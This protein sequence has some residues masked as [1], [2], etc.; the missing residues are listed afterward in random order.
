M[1]IKYF[2]IGNRQGANQ[3]RK[4]F[5]FKYTNNKNIQKKFLDF[6]SSY[7]SREDNSIAIPHLKYNYVFSLRLMSAK[8]NCRPTKY[9]SE[10]S[11]IKLSFFLKHLQ[12]SSHHNQ[13]V[14]S[15]HGISSVPIKEA[16]INGSP[17]P[18]RADAN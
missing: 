12:V 18:R 10:R 15:L 9:I 7:Y 13:S 3:V 8:P 1:A 16:G 6:S 14:I 4:V 5:F 11:A 17:S 2:A